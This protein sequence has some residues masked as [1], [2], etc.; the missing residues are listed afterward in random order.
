[1]R[2]IISCHECYADPVRITFEDF[3][4]FYMAIR[5]DA[6]ISGCVICCG[7]EV[8]FAIVLEADI[9]QHVNQAV[10]GQTFIPN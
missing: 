2:K 8:I 1:M 6:D 5:F 10:E 3:K 9:M 4:I 7:S